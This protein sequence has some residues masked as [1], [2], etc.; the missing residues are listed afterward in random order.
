MSIFVFAIAFGAFFLGV[1]VGAVCLS[2]FSGARIID[3]HNEVDELR[4]KVSA[5]HDGQKTK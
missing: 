4:R 3:L 5:Q 2:V 1:I